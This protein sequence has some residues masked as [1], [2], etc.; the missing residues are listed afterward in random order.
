MTANCVILIVVIDIC[1]CLIVFRLSLWGPLF[2]TV[3]YYLILVE[4]EGN[5]S[6]KT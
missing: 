4:L 5:H 2:V 3:M 6:G 1:K